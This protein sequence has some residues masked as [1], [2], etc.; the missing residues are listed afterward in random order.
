MKGK[1]V[2]EIIGLYEIFGGSIGIGLILWGTIELNKI[3]IFSV[4][5]PLF[6]LAFYFFSIYAGIKLLKYYEKK[7]ILSEILQ[8]IQI[9]SFGIFG[10]FLT[11]SAGITFLVGFDYTH[12]F[13]FRFKFD[14]VPS[15]STISILSDESVFYFYVNLIPIVILIILD[16]IR[17]KSKVEEMTTS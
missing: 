14:F 13:L 1:K 15:N 5:L 16:R 7:I 2:L 12:E 4:F 10:F 6:L 3:T 11:L 17:S 8:Y 9:L